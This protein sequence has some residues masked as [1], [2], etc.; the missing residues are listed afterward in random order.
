MNYVSETTVSMESCDFHAFGPMG[1]TEEEQASSPLKSTS[2]FRTDRAKHGFIWIVRK[3]NN[4]H[5]IIPP[6]AEE[7]IEEMLTGK[8][9]QVCSGNTMSTIVFEDFSPAPFAI[10]C[11]NNQIGGIFDDAY[12]KPKRKGY[13]AIYK[14]GKVCPD[15]LGD[16]VI[17]VG[18]MDLWVNRAF[19]DNAIRKLTEQERSLYE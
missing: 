1:T 10:Q 19:T 13:L 17:E 6:L 14:K 4:Y 7:T 18:R 8:F 11:D 9:C 12:D 3:C 2:Y 15:E 16:E 5:L